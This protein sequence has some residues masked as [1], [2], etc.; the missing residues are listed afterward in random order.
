MMDDAAKHSYNCSSSTELTCKKETGAR[1][2]MRIRKQEG[3][4]VKDREN[5]RNG[6]PEVKIEV[7]G[8]NMR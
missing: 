1:R 4:G 2:E 7:K 5:V 8:R 3:G 6:L